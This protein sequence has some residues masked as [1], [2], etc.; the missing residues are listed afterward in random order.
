MVALDTSQKTLEE[1][2]GASAPRLTGEGGTAEWDDNVGGAERNKKFPYL[3]VG[4][5]LCV[6]PTYS[7][8]PRY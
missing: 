4:M 2:N 3:V 8:H 6:V 7:L 1:T 5:R